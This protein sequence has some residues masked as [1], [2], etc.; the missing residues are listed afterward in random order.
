VACRHQDRP[1]T[2]AE[3]DAVVAMRRDG[4]P[5]AL[6]AQ[7]L[8]RTVQAVNNRIQKFL[9]EGRLPRY[10]VSRTT[11]TPY[12]VTVG[13]YRP[14]EG[15]PLAHVLAP[16]DQQEEDEEAFLSRMLRSADTSIARAEAQRYAVIR[17]AA[18]RP[19]ALSLS[20]DWHVA[21]TGTDLR[22]LVEYADFVRGTPHLYAV[23]VGDLTDNPIKH[24]G[25]SVQQVADE[26]RALDLI[27]G[28]FGGKLLGMT[29]GNHDDWSK[30]LAGVD[31]LAALS[32]RHRIHYAPD[33]LLWRVEIV[34]PHAPD[35][36][37]ATYHIYTRHQWRRGSA[38]NPGH[39]CWTW[40]QEEGPNWDV[41]P[42]VLAIGHSH[43]AVVES[44][45]FA[46]RDMWALRIGTW[47]R[48]SAFARAKGFARYR[49]TCPT[50]VLHPD[51]SRR[52]QCF[53]DPAAA[54]RFM[55][56]DLEDSPY[57]EL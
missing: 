23:A 35:E 49:S 31:N 54:V 12:D 14:P 17:L 30:T 57:A 22:G 55:N 3:L 8:G 5:S 18:D 16:A 27:V 51:R 2:E 41:V 38:L 47:Q 53:A 7:R 36:V 25:G 37:T 10:H 42:D 20:S 33:E 21:P 26:L 40:Y 19:V 45:Q 50:V 29:S 24:R 4:E 44:R 6:I 32:R 11:I 28:R 52:L 9:R 43:V 34:A 1:W 15:P 39:A 46:E 56:G 48:D 13:G